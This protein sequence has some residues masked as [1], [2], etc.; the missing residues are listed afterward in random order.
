MG[1]FLSLAALSIALAVNTNAQTQ[2]SLK[3]AYKDC[4]MVGA[5]LNPAQFS[6]RDQVEDA[7]IKA[8]FNTISPENVLKWENVHP[9]TDTYDFVPA[10]K[11]VEFGERN[12]MFIIGHAL[13]WHSQVP[14]W[15]FEH[16]KGNPVTR[17]VLLDRMR[18]H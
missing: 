2:P 15:V 14:K 8:Q 16:D 10:D 3:D 1:K 7:I 18:D 5:A 13:V 6:E 11:Y 4:F 17:D 9:Q 12:R